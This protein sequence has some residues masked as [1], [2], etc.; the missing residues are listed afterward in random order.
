MGRPVRLF[1]QFACSE[2]QG[3]SMKEVKGEQ[4]KNF[5]SSGEQAKWKRER[6]GI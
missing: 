1:V 2:H 5:Q 6:R 4:R 3:E